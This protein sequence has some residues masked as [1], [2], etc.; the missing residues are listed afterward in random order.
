MSYSNIEFT[1]SAQADYIIMT[2]RAIFNKNENQENKL[3]NCFNKF[4]G[5]NIFKVERN[6]LILSNIRK[7]YNSSQ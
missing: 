3:I 6:G 7:I 5:D 4:K 2:N 1:D